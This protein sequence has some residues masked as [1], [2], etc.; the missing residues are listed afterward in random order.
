MSW[1]AFHFC[2]LPSTSKDS[3]KAFTIIGGF[4]SFML[5]LMLLDACFCGVMFFDN[6]GEQFHNFLAVVFLQKRH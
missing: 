1:F 5:P 6:T 2:D 3:I 4:T